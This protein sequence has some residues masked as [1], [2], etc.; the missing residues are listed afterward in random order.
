MTGTLT[1]RGVLIWL[2]GFFA[3]IF[4]TNA[5]FITMSVKTFRG[6]DEQLPYLQGISFNQTLTHRAEQQAL[7]WH[8]TVAVTR[9]PH[10]SAQV[11]VNIRDARGGPLSGVTLKGTLR[12]PADENRDRPLILAPVAPGIYQAKVDQLP[13]GLWNVTMHA[14]GGPPFELVDRLW[15]R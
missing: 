5:Y 10:G 12:H 7:G 13:P 4:A 9:L 8:A 1:G 15:V 6:E 11:E 2:C 3:L 14:E